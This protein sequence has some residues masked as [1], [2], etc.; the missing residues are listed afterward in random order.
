MV[1][2]LDTDGDGEVSKEEW[3]SYTAEMNGGDADAQ[4]AAEADFDV[5]DADGSGTVTVAEIQSVFNSKWADMDRSQGWN[6][7]IVRF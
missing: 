1:A 7:N 6:V 5:F 3:L 2:G 4:A